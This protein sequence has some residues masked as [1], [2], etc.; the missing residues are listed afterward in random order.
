MR[1]S[2]NSIR[3]VLLAE[4]QKYNLITGFARTPSLPVTPWREDS[5]RRHEQQ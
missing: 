5:H 4:V 1:Q 3:S 2:P